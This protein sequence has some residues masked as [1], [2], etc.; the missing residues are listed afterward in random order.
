MRLYVVTIVIHV[1]LVAFI[2]LNHSK[3]TDALIFQNK[4]W[5]CV[6]LSLIVAIQF[7]AF[8]VSVRPIGGTLW[9]S[10]GIVSLIYIC[11]AVS[12]M[13]NFAELGYPKPF[14]WPDCMPNSIYGI[15]TSI[16]TEKNLSTAMLATSVTMYLIAHLSVVLTGAC[17][18]STIGTMMTIRRR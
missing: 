8:V 7:P 9:A 11:I 18:N 6:I 17:L 10:F 14:P 2:A 1:L 4:L 13:Y 16:L 15:W 5:F 3:L 12:R